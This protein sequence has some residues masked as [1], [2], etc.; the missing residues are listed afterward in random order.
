[1]FVNNY[2]LRSFNYSWL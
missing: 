2:M 1:M